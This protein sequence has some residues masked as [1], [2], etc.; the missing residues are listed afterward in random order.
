MSF[1]FWDGEH[2]HPL[3]CVLQ[4]GY[5]RIFSVNGF[6]DCRNLLLGGSSILI[7]P[8]NLGNPSEYAAGGAE[9]RYG[10]KQ[11]ESKPAIEDECPIDLLHET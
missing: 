2:A 3:N 5:L 4:V 10:R 7:A 6:F 11:D 9:E 8:A 1:H